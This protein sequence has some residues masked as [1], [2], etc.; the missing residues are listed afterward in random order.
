MVRIQISVQIYMNAR[1]IKW[2]Y[3]SNTIITDAQQDHHR[4]GRVCEIVLN[5]LVGLKKCIDLIWVSVRVHTTT[6]IIIENS[7]FKSL[8]TSIIILCKITHAVMILESDFLSQKRAMSQ[9][10]TNRACNTP[11]ALS[12]YFRHASCDWAKKVFLASW[13]TGGLH[14]C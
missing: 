12:I 5:M 11:S 3:I 8:S 14:K 9:T 7:N 4:G 6:N 1:K 2:E 10:L 13:V